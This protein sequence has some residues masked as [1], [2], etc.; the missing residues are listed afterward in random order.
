[1]PFRRYCEIAAYIG[2]FIFALTYLATVALAQ[3]QTDCSVGSPA[4]D[5]YCGVG[6]GTP[7]PPGPAGPP[8]ADSTV[9]GPQGEQGPPGPAGADS[10]VPGPPGPQGIQ[11]VPGFGTPD[12]LANTRALAAALGT[13]IWLQETEK[14]TLSGSIGLSDGSQAIGI[15][16]AI[17]LQGSTAITGSA[18]IGEGEWAGRI[19]LRFGGK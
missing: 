10:T 19:G 1:M 8:G 15:G 7:G 6:S 2:I 5:G 17:R 3:A 9:P 13:P 16:G 14:W 12:D 4:F 11:G 18:A